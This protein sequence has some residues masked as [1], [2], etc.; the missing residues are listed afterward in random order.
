MKDATPDLRLLKAI[1]W[2][3][4]D[5]R[6]SHTVHDFHWFRAKFIPQIPAI[7][8]KHFTEVN[9]VVL[10]PFCGCGTTLVESLRFGRRAIGI[11]IVPLACL[12]SKVKTCLI[13]PPYLSKKADNLLSDLKRDFS[14]SFKKSLF[15]TKVVKEIDD[16]IRKYV[17]DFPNKERWYHSATLKGLGIIKAHIDAEEDEDVKDFYTVCFSS[18]LK[19]CSSQTNHW[20]YVADNMLPRK[21]IYR[22]AYY[23]FEKKLFRMTKGMAELYED[24][25]KLGLSMEELNQLCSVYNIDARNMDVIGSNSVDLVITSPPYPNVTDQT[26]MHRL[27][28]YWLGI[29]M[30][31]YKKKEI[32]AR[33]KRGRKTALKDYFTEMEECFVQVY[34]VM[35]DRAYLCVVLGSPKGDS[36]RSH[37]IESLIG[38]VKE[39]GFL[40]ITKFERS[41]ISQAI[42][43]KQFP[44]EEILIFQKKNRK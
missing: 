2:T 5:V 30:E 33:W 28:F 20:G 12:I 19:R 3:L 39:L 35:K 37:T 25:R 14:V 11:D 16:E 43:A 21:M 1:D 10:D 31:Y 9:D 40:F 8:I 26:K 15:G 36:V 42:P 38:V 34:R 29:D 6:T 7:L 17:P 41:V 27:S 44:E 24:C 32:G 13:E 4:R 22:D 23:H 18:I